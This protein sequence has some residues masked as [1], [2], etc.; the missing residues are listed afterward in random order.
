MCGKAKSHLG[1]C[2]VN[3]PLCTWININKNKSLHQVRV[4]ELWGESRGTLR[5]IIQTTQWSTAGA[6]A[7]KLLAKGARQTRELLCAGLPVAPSKTRLNSVVALR[8][9]TVPIDPAVPSGDLCAWHSCRSCSGP[10]CYRDQQPSLL[11]FSTSVKNLDK[12]L[13]LES[14]SFSSRKRQ[15]SQ[16]KWGKWHGF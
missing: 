7:G 15:F 6:A 8:C 12:L 3:P 9:S 1:C 2:P 14:T 5:R 13:C 11:Q 4:A 16:W 10:V